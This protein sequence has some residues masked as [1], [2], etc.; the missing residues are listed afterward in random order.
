[1]PNADG[2][3]QATALTD[4]ELGARLDR[5][6]PF[7]R[8]PRL[9]VAVSGGADSLMLALLADGWARV[10]GGGIT[11]LTVDH[12]LRPESAAEARQ[13]GEWLAARG[14]ARQTLVWNGP[15]PRGDIQAAARAARYRLM[16]GWC[17]EH[18][19]LHLLTAHHLEDRAETFWLRLARGSGL[20]GL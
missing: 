6:G 16:E 8:A 2:D 17:A 3:N 10:R 4:E 13:T 9:A 14:I 7:E 1:M 12:G 15:H 20:D 5:L 11:A 19:C 18:R